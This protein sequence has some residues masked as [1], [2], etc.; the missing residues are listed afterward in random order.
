MVAIVSGNGAGI[1]NTS[2]GTLGQGGVFG[3][4]A[5]GNSKDSVY[6][7]IANG[8][9]LLQD[10]DDCIVARGVDSE[11]VRTYN[12]QGQLNTGDGVGWRQATRRQL[13][14]LTGTVNTAGSTITRIVGDG[15]ATVFTYDVARA[16]YFTTEGGGAYQ[17]IT[18]S[19]ANNQWTWQADHND[20]YGEHEVY[21]GTT[22]L[23]YSAT[24]YRYGAIFY[25]TH[26]SSNRLTKLTNA[27]GDTTYFDYVNGNVSKV[28]TVMAGVTGDFSR[29]SYQYDAL[30]RLTGVITDLT[31]E[32]KADAK[33]YT[34]NYTY[35]SN[36][37]QVET[38]TQS[39][40][41]RLNFTYVLH[42]GKNKVASV[43]DALGRSTSFDYTQPGKTIVTDSLGFKT[44]YA[45]D[46]NGQLLSVTAP[47][48]AGVSQ[49]TQFEYDAAGNISRTVD[50]RGLATTYGYDGNG[51]RILERDST[52]ATITRTF[53][54]ANKVLS[55]T[56][57]IDL[58][59]DGAGGLLP[60]QKL[61]TRYVYD[62]Y[63]VVRFII[64]PEGRVREYRYNAQHQLLVDLAYIGIKFAENSAE[65]AYA[66]N[67][68]VTWSQSTAVKAAA[69]TRVDY[70]YDGR[71]LVMQST[72]YAATA[73]ASNAAP[74]IG[75]DTA[76]VQYV[77][78]HAGQLLQSIDGNG[79]T[80]TYA[81]DGLGRQ[82]SATDPQ[83]NVVL[84]T[85]DDAGNRIVTR[86]A[87]GVTSTSTYDKSGQ[88]LA[89]VLAEA[90]GTVVG[91]SSYL[92]D[93]A[94]K[95]RTVIDPN[96]GRSHIL[97]DEA[98]RKAATVTAA[99][100]LTEYRYDANNQLALTI[101][102]ATSVSQA[103]LAAL[104]GTD[105]KPV[106][107]TLETAGLRPAATA[108]D[109]REWRL[110]DNANRLLKTVDAL[111]YVTD[112]SYDGASRLLD[113]IRRATVIDLT[114]FAANPNVAN[115]SPAPHANDRVARNSYDKD[116]KLRFTMDG[117]GYLSE[118]Q[119]DL[120]GRHTGTVRYAAAVDPAARSGS[121]WMTAAASSVG[122]TASTTYDGR[123]QVVSQTDGAGN[124]TTFTY[125]GQGN[126]LTSTTAGVAT[127]FVYDKLN[128]LIESHADANAS[129]VTSKVAYDAQ[130]NKVAVTD[131]MGNTTRLVYDASNR[132]VFSIDPL[133]IVTE[134]RYNAN[135][136]AVA[137]IRYSKAINVVSAEQ[138]LGASDVRAV[139]SADIES[140]VH[141]RY[142]RDGRLT[143][144]VDATGAATQLVYDAK[145]NVVR[146]IAYK[147]ALGTDELASLAANPGAVPVPAN[148]FTATSYIYDENDRLVFTIDAM[149]AVAESRYDAQGNVIETVRYATP[150]DTS[151]TQTPAVLAVRALLR[152]DAAKDV[153]EFRRYDKEGHL[154][155]SV[156]AAGAATQFI[157]DAN[158]NVVKRLA[159]T[160]PLTAAAL[161]SLAADACALPAPAG[162]S[163]MTQFAYDGDNRLVFTVDPLGIVSENRY[164][165]RGNVVETVRYAV[166]I[167]LANDAQLTVASIKPLLLADAKDVH[168]FQR[169]D[170]LGRLAWSVDGT[171][172][173]T[174]L[175]YDNSGNLIKRLA[176][177][178]R[179]TPAAMA[180]L[181]GNASEL[182]AP[183][184]ASA[185]TQYAYDA[186]NRLV[187]TVDALGI[188]TENRYDVNGKAV[189]TVRYATPVAV[190]D[191]T[192][193]LSA[194]AIKALVQADAAK[195]VHQFQ[196]YDKDGRLAWSVD[197]TGAVTQL[198]YDT[199]HR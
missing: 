190:G 144:T 86:R 47:A 113:T 53:S 117:E 146:R 154:T 13:T 71:G 127:C 50:A 162:A 62:T 96:G 19:A 186:D 97:Y 142:D 94:G 24:D 56:R 164:D 112:Y 115:A 176:F 183:T 165:V 1:L 32:N 75:P 125:D 66:Y 26:D 157:Y 89:T 21:N 126:V 61:T 77:Y 195:D 198:I 133:G 43:T 63:N 52:G 72:S 25:F 45:Y 158:G 82:L 12:S 185:M 46:A 189:E 106:T 103:S 40:G 163:S 107:A 88:L 137:T 49:I 85:Y 110:Y 68:M 182:P 194:A 114:A 116:G 181:A 54:S 6:I 16:A 76:I 122:I 74:A 23:I 37:S 78:D 119:Y 179:L 167:T 99:G 111:G 156:D 101:A 67:A 22:G 64:S 7:N 41:T 109:Q 100:S 83:Q 138:V 151:N 29:V 153:H 48:V 131:A 28:R 95:L 197:G 196:R 124:T 171:G 184:G 168:Q 143:W 27:H 38:V 187:F 148:E 79:N 129:N 51:N 14:G 31:P 149:G 65:S 91:T 105:G 118:F 102:Y 192:Q 59:P 104:I 80:T 58:D 36:T 84:H 121:G 123:G 17:T 139:L 15:S 136:N 140:V 152:V 150:I 5:N 2:A 90:N 188:V 87:D 120:A 44:A 175:F 33:T 69:A 173:A 161:A 11:I 18:F 70:A 135:G 81:Y 128:R 10:Q 147:N 93:N 141:Q 178:E 4:A 174:Q 155:W 134:T 193:Q 73:G 180:S 199:Q 39:D 42:D 60:T 92:Y 160:D 159:Y 8:N 3:N 172:A 130:G 20:L 145:G 191:S 170:A 132:Q 57:Y 55:E 35:L 169:Y 9:L 34:V 30:N 166:P 108:A 177:T 98:G